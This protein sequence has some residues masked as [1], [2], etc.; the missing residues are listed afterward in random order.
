MCKIIYFTIFGY[1]ITLAIAIT[2]FIGC[3]IRFCIDYGISMLS[4]MQ[5]FISLTFNVKIIVSLGP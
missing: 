4:A 3:D 1:D 2:L 5:L